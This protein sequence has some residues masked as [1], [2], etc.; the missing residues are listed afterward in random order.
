MV[1]VEEAVEV[2]QVRGR[3]AFPPIE[4]STADGAGFVIES[5]DFRSVDL[6]AEA[7]KSGDGAL[8]S[9]RRASDDLMFEELGY[10]AE[11]LD[12]QV[13]AVLDSVIDGSLVRRLVRIY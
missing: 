2:R 9:V 4:V 3:T 1:P 5:V 8:P 7:L 10:H 13:R 11:P 6:V 12:Q